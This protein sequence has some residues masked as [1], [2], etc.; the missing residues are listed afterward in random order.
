MIGGRG[1]V[2]AP[3]IWCD[4][5]SRHVLRDS[6]PSAVGACEEAG[7]KYEPHQRSEGGRP[8]TGTDPSRR[9]AVGFGDRGRERE[10]GFSA[11]PSVLLL[12]DHVLARRTP[13]LNTSTMMCI[14]RV[15][16]AN[17]LPSHAPSDA[18]LSP[19]FPWG[20]VEFPI[21]MFNAQGTARRIGP[22]QISIWICEGATKKRRV[23]NRP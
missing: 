15:P 11:E 7:I 10:R 6:S 3:E 13:V 4:G 18:A 20:S 1:A 9:E 2:P 16:F 19:P 5:L 22:A 12:R 21:P 8:S 17:C 14:I 23:S